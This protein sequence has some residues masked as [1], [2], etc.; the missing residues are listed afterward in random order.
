MSAQALLWNALQKLNFLQSPTHGHAQKI[1]EKRDD[2][3]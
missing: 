3:D 1:G 2:L